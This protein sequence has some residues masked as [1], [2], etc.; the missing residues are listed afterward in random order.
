MN[1]A[2]IFAGGVGSRMNNNPMP[3]QFLEINGKPIIIHT[4]EI[5]ENHPKID[6]IYVAC[7][8]P[9]IPH[10][11]KLVRKYCIE[12]LR[13]IAPGGETSQQS[14]YNALNCIDEFDDE[15]IVLIH[16]GVRPLVDHA[17]VTRSIAHARQHG[18]AVTCVSAY[19]T[20]V[21]SDESGR[22]VDVLDRNSIKIARAPQTFFLKDIFDV[23]KKAL[24]DGV[25][26]VI[27]SCSLM[28]L[29]EKDVH[30]VEG[31]Y[32]NIKVTT[33]EDFYILRSL[34]EIRENMQIMGI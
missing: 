16:D 10:L 27:D 20:V 14:I 8:E 18:S 1:H 29:Y 24:A 23:H 3:K 6:G 33:P 31:R 25:S 2:V 12:K 17:T 21:V 15:T 22:V 9:W 28:R 4:L 11:Q 19:E 7:N 34:F 30:T 26:N 13:E 32:E 5:F